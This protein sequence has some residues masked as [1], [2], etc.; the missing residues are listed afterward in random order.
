MDGTD[1]FAAGRLLDGPCGHEVGNVVFDLRRNAWSTKLVEGG[2]CQFTDCVEI[3]A[4]F[5]QHEL[6]DN[7]EEFIAD[8]EFGW[9]VGLAR[10][11]VAATAAEKS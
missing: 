5:E 3:F 6:L 1:L 7:A 8:G 9:C 10:D 4:I 11:F 2:R